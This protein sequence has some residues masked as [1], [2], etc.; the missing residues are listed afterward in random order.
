MSIHLIQD[1]TG[2][3]YSSRTA[4]LFWK[5]S[6]FRGIKK[7]HYSEKIPDFCCFFCRSQ[8]AIKRLH[9]SEKFP[10]FVLSS[11]GLDKLDYTC[12]ARWPEGLLCLN[13]STDCLKFE[14]LNCAKFSKAELCTIRLLK[15]NPGFDFPT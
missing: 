3:I 12:R 1:R 4:T 14:N 15:S 9:Y 7:L 13:N 2:L 5:V 8:R 11:A 6:G 10:D